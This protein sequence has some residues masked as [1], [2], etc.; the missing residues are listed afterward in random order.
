MRKTLLAAVIALFFSLPT[1]A[2][3]FGPGGC[4]WAGPSPTP[5]P[6]APVDP[7]GPTDLCIRD[8]CQ[9]VFYSWLGRKVVAESTL[10]NGYEVMGWAGPCLNPIPGNCPD[11]FNQAHRDLLNN[12][13][14]R[15]RAQDAKP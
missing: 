15:N 4:T 13:L 6:P 14:I 2:Q 11:I 7:T 12:A 5:P 9:P 1:F 8:Q 10:P 3:C